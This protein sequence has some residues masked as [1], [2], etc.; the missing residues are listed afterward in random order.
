MMT[1]AHGRHHPPCSLLP[2]AGQ[3]Y[4]AAVPHP[5]FWIQTALRTIARQ[6]SSWLSAFVRKESP[7]PARCCY[8]S[9]QGATDAV[10]VAAWFPE[11]CECLCASVHISVHCKPLCCIDLIAAG[12]RLKAPKEGAHR[13]AVRR[14]LLQSTKTSSAAPKLSASM[15]DRYPFP[16][17]YST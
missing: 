16:A 3:A 5:E 13:S 8:K 12:K 17:P 9:L 14:K 1:V 2:E 10:S 15:Q 11:G 7:A 6:R 4:D